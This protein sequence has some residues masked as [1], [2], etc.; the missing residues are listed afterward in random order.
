MRLTKTALAVSQPT[1]PP[2][3]IAHGAAIIA[4]FL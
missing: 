2:A 4:F 3:Q 1:A